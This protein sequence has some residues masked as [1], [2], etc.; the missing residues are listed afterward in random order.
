MSGYLYKGTDQN[1][2]WQRNCQSLHGTQCIK[3]QKKINERNTAKWRHSCVKIGSKE[4]IQQEVSQLVLNEYFREKQFK[5]TLWV[6]STSVKIY[7]RGTHL[8]WHRREELTAQ[9]H[10]VPTGQTEALKPVLLLPI[11]KKHCT[12]WLVTILYPIVTINI[13]LHA[14]YFYYDR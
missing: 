4:F 1:R 7:P 3:A 2:H 9:G 13:I 14:S 11:Y 5:T 10:Q 8:P 6:C 12:V